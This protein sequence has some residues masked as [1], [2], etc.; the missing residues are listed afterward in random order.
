LISVEISWKE[1]IS[2]ALIANKYVE[3]LEQYLSK[4][5]LTTTK[6]SRVFIDSQLKKAEI[7]LLDAEEKLKKF[8]EKY[9]IFRVDDQAIVEK[10]YE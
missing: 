10:D 1:A 7:Q 2:A 4:N 8:S 6:K 9:G 5:N 3:E